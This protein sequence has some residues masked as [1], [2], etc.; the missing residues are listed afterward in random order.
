[1]TLDPSVNTVTARYGHSLALH[2]VREQMHQWIFTENKD[3]VQ[4][5]KSTAY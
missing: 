4:D 3:I 2:E 1:M 5:S